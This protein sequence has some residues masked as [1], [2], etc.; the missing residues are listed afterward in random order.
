VKLGGGHVGRAAGFAAILVVA[1][2][3]R[4]SSFPAALASGEMLP[5]DGDSAYHLLRILR[6]AERFP[7]VPV[8]D[9]DTNWPAGGM[10]PWAG[11]FDVGGAAFVLALGGARSSQRARLLAGLYP[12]VLGLLVVWA[13]MALA[14]AVAPERLREPVALASGLL[15]ALIPQGVAASRFAR[16]DHH[17][18]EALA[19]VLLARWVLTRPAAME[20]ARRRLLFEVEGA[21]LSAGAVYVFAGAT[22][23]VALAAT[24]AM[25][26]T[27]AGR[28]APPVVGSGAPAL[29]L[30]GGLAA[31]L[32]LPAISEHGRWLSFVFPSLLQPVLV[33]AAGAVLALAALA[34]RAL[35]RA[36]RTARA[37]AFL[38]AGAV[39]VAAGAIAW[40]GLAS[41]V[42]RGIG[43]WLFRRDP[44]L[45]RIDEFQPLW[46]HPGYGGAWAATY[47]FFGIAGWLAPLSLALG[48]SEAVR[49]G[50]E[51]GLGFA[52]MATALFLLTLLQIRF[53]R[54][55]APFLAVATALALAWVA[56][57][58]CAATR[59]EWNGGGVVLLS[60]AV[61]A[62]VDPRLRTRLAISPPAV[63]DAI[64]SAA[65]DLR[66]G[67]PRG[68]VA[69]RWDLGH[70][71]EAI[72]G[73][74]VVANGFGTYLDRSGFEEMAHLGLG[75]EAELY[76]TLERR[77]LGFLVGGAATMPGR[78]PGTS[79]AVFER[80]E[81]GAVVLGRAYL[82]ALPLSPLLV[83]GSG[84]PALDVRH[85]SRLLPRFAS[86]QRV[87]GISFAL[88]V[89]W[90]YERV[91]GARLSGAAAPGARVVAELP[92]RE[93]GWPHTY[94]AWTDAGADGRWDLVVPVPTDFARPTLWTGPR[95]QVRAGAGAPV[96]VA[97][98]ESAVRAGSLIAVGAPPRGVTE[99]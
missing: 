30:G 21:L 17:V 73:R 44:W 64:Q 90:V 83:A 7:H 19:M 20:G 37:A 69:A 12:V 35:P 38:A 80:G 56:R 58:V 95:W 32:F 78:A 6:T 79:A 4:L 66:G 9:P 43:G 97:V 68:G 53:G 63:P 54:V 5:P 98:P 65:L 1:A 86:A 59:R 76:A 96:P 10:C 24:V 75:S 71:V 40:P 45:S 41:E 61:L 93:H 99:R 51:R 70:Y 18:L 46:S 89:L 25:V 11:G 14:R 82:R 52:A 92:F 2:W 57:A 42:A 85:L 47:D 16:V 15:V 62:A 67:K 87:A 94:R 91:P 48:G 74:P 33:A 81:N 28:D 34:G 77:D 13:T 31:V 55:F 29:L 72:G 8:F 3:A 84:V 27:L 88:P 23:Y 26:S 22:V 60:V 36:G 39:C 50:R 49:A